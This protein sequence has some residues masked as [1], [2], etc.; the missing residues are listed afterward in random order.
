VTRPAPAAALAVLVLLGAC[1][2]V[3][4]GAEPDG[5]A[6][7]SA[8]STP[9]EPAGSPRAEKVVSAVE[10]EPGLMTLRDRRGDVWREVGHAGRARPVQDAKSPIADALSLV[11]RHRPEE[12][13]VTVRFDDLRPLGSQEVN[14]ELD[15]PDEI[16]SG[17]SVHST[18][19][20]R[21][22]SVGE[23]YPRCP[24]ATAR[25]DF[26]ADTVVLSLPR[27]CLGDPRWV[28]IDGADTGLYGVGGGALYG[29][30][31][32][33]DRY[34]AFSVVRRVPVG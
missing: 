9:A 21:S 30:N 20:R 26:E 19:S 29:E 28:A 34:D 17:V 18:P 11:L 6:T 4:K 16:D 3:E 25:Y 12:V 5:R 31:L 22:G 1:G 32:F 13:R 33:N 27:R 24:D 23:S 10:V 14:L 2:Q 7:P 15:L 8:E